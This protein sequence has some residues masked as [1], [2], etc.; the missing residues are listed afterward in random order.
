MAE[1]LGPT[2]F[3]AEIDR[4]TKDGKLPPL[5]EVLDAVSSARQKYAHHII[6]ARHQ[7]EKGE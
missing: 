6:T 4:L 1:K 5:D 3:Q 2:Q 7:E